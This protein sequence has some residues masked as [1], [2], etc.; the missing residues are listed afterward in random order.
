[1][2]AAGFTLEN[3]LTDA[4]E[5]EAQIKRLMVG[6]ARE[7]IAVVDHTKWERAAFATFCR[8]DQLTAVVAD[9]AR[10]RQMVEALP[11]GASTSAP[12]AGGTTSAGRARPRGNALS[13]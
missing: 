12:E 8:T 13:R 1:M 10:R 11:I 9:D 6:A 4:T 2:G 3:G 5:E 7:V